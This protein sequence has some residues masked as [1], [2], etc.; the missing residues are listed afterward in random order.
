M[1]GARVGQRL[2]E[3]GAGKVPQLMEEVGANRGMAH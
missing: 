1:S 3:R 2:A